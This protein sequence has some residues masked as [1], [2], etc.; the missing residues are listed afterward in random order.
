ML[1]LQRF[2]H[3]I[4]RNKVLWLIWAVMLVAILLNDTELFTER[5]SALLQAQSGPAQI[6]TQFVRDAIARFPQD[7]QK[8]QTVFESIVFGHVISA[9]FIQ[10][11]IVHVEVKSPAEYGSVYLDIIGYLPNSAGHVRLRFSP[12]GDVNNIRELALTLAMGLGGWLALG[13]LLAILVLFETW[14]PPWQSPG[15]NVPS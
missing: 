9:Q 4:W 5:Y 12:A 7:E 1:L 10:N 11:G 8:I 3:L 2:K 6:L 15:R 14:V 13:L